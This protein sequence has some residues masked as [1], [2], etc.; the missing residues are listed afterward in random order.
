M[1]TNKYT[2]RIRTHCCS[3]SLS[4]ALITS[5]CH[6]VTIVL[7]PPEVMNIYIFEIFQ[8]QV[9]RKHNERKEIFSLEASLNHYQKMTNIGWINYQSSK[10]KNKTKQ[11]DKEERKNQLHCNDHF[12]VRANLKYNIVNDICSGQFEF[13]CLCAIVS[14]NKRSSHVMMTLC[15]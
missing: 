7:K 14:E 5:V 4:L 15:Q 3:L 6:Y 10:W 12:M 2:L 11:N 13:K 1:P 8:F 9:N